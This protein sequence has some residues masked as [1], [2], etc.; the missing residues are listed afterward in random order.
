MCCFHLLTKDNGMMHFEIGSFYDSLHILEAHHAP[1]F[2]QIT[3]VAVLG[4]HHVAL[5][6]G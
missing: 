2:L 5:V 3:K 6:Y 1:S 4:A